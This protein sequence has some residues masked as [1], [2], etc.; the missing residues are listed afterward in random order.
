MAKQLKWYSIRW[1]TVLV[2]LLLAAGLWYLLVGR[3][4]RPIGRGSAGPDVPAAAFARSWSERRT[5]LLGVGDSITRGYGA[6]PGHGYFELLVHNDDAAYPDMAGRG[7]SHVFPD[8][9][10]RNVSTSYT[11]SLEH[12]E[13]QVPSIP[14][15]PAAVHGI[16]VVT[17]GGNDLIHDYGRSEPRDGAIYGCTFDQGRAWAERYRG[18]L[19]RIIEGVTERFPGGCTIF[20]A[21]VYDP[22]DGVGD[23]EHAAPGLPDWPDGLQVHTHFNRVIAEVCAEF[24]HV[25]L[26]D[27]HALFLGHGIHCRDRRNPHYRRAD[28]HYWYYA[29]LEDPNDR[30]YDAL[31]RAFLLKMIDVLPQAL[32]ARELTTDR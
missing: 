2:A 25:H 23:I 4:H 19:R 9:A 17:S 8:L 20:V 7:L 11:V 22:T 6:A 3:Y 13:D 10:V 31:R 1:Q 32:R 24:E 15:Q 28:P 29:N 18:R 21:N 16:V 5:L 12:L 14:L 30:G 26:V 27:I